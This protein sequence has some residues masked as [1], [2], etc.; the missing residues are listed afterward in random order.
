MFLKSPFSKNP[1]LREEQNSLMF[2]ESVVMMGHFPE[3]KCLRL[4]PGAHVSLLTAL[5]LLAGNRSE[6]LK[7]DLQLT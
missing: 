5:E 6:E 7:P 3:Q 1:D 2:T 4:L